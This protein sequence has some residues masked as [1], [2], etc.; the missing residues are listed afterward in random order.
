M[1]D[2]VEAKVR[3]RHYN[4]DEARP[5]GLRRRIAEETGIDIDEVVAKRYDDRSADEQALLQRYLR[6]LYGVKEQTERQASPIEAAKRIEGGDDAIMQ[7][8][9]TQPQG[10]GG[11]PPHEEGG[12]SAAPRG[13]S[14]QEAIDAM[15]KAYADAIDTFGENAEQYGAAL[16]DDPMSL[17]GSG[18]LD[19]E[20]EAAVLA[21][22]NARERAR[23]AVADDA[24]AAVRSEVDSKAHRRSGVLMPATMRDGR[25][26]YVVQ[27]DVAVNDDGSVN[28]GESSGFLI[29]ADAKTGE[30]FS[31]APKFISALG[32]AVDKRTAIEMALKQQA[33]ANEQS[34]PATAAIDAA[35]DNG[36]MSSPQDLPIEPTGTEKQTQEQ[37]PV[38]RVVGNEDAAGGEL[39][40]LQRI[41]VGEDGEPMFEQA[42]NPEHGWDAL[43]EYCDGDKDMAG[44]IAEQMA[45]KKSKEYAQAQKLKAN[46]AG[47]AALKESI[48][49]NKAKIEA[50]KAAYDFWRKA[51]AVENARKEA[52]LAQQEAAARQAAAERAAAE[53][54]EREAREEAA[55]QEREALEGIPE[56]HLDTPENARKRGARR[57][58]G[59]MFTRQEPVQGVVG[60]DVEVKFSQKDM[61]KGRV[62]VIEASQLQPS[63]IQ[64]Q[65][66]PMFFIEEAQPKNR[67]EA[68]SAFAAKEMAERIRPQEITGSA[69]A[70]T[71]A[72]T[73]NTRG[74]V[75]QGNNRSDALRYLWENELPEQ[76]QTYKQYLLDNAEQFGID[77]EAVNAMQHPVLVNML[78]VDDAEAIRLGQMTAQDTESGGVERIKPKNVAQKLGDDMRSFANRLLSS[79]D[80]EA[81][82]GQL[83]DRNGTE[84]LKWMNQTGAITSTQFQSAFDSKGNLT[85]EAKNDLQKVLYQAVFKGGSQQLEEMF[86]KL[87][88]KAQRAILATAFRDMDSPLAGKLLPEIQASIAAY[89]QLMNDPTFANA[90]N[91]EKLL[92][93][94]ETFKKATALDD[95]FEIYVPA[96][97]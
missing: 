1:I 21:F 13:T 45:E 44:Q 67:A 52:I 39:T 16:N 61:P 38:P 31:T 90:K 43:V 8:D 6:E 72:P 35:S 69:T 76:Q 23:R 96:D 42:E 73:V 80:E 54:A 86:D 40:A 75:I 81:T 27:G 51:A 17:L 20:Q 63:H 2:A 57:F 46:G 50:A 74:E 83:V 95:R 77:P 60:K 53:K 55:R 30:Y 18:V 12:N 87:P 3:S 37:S 68:V 5:Q 88:A 93:A 91:M 49:Q 26:V 97:N 71:G 14:Q 47:V 28:V 9:T 10:G 65:R 22:Y 92:R 64:G 15:N 94:I 84:V 25:E 34:A 85:A 59:Q 70:Y 7:D 41:P 89:V 58:S 4:I 33:T 19:G 29:V 24:E 79:G 56:W 82:F 78:D 32:E 11:V 48:R 36:A 66:N 62:V